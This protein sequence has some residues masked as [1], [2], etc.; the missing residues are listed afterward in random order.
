VKYLGQVRYVSIE[1]SGPWRSLPVREG[2]EGRAFLCAALDAMR[3]THFM[4]RGGSAERWA[5]GQGNAGKRGNAMFFVSL[6]FFVKDFDGLDY[7][8]RGGHVL[9]KADIAGTRFANF[10]DNLKTLD[11]LAKHGIAPAIGIGIVE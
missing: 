9:V 1:R 7:H 2:W 5:F 11:D 8:G 6:F 4:I 3:L 10:F